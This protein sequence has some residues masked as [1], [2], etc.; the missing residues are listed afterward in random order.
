M[1]RKKKECNKKVETRPN[2]EKVRVRNYPQF[3]FATE[4]FSDETG[5]Y[6]QNC[7]QN[8]KLEIVTKFLSSVLGIPKIDSKPGFF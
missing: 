3:G 7:F 2:P 1:Q 5:Q 8:Q 4:H 6:F